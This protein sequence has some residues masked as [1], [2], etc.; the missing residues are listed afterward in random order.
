[1]VVFF[2]GEMLPKSIAKKYAE[3]LAMRTARS[4]RFFMV[5]FKPLSALLTAFGNAVAR[6]VQSEPAVT[7]TED[8]L[9]D[10]RT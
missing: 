9:A 5:L 1:M 2:A 4:L 3:R 10:I 6:R 8:E 7:V